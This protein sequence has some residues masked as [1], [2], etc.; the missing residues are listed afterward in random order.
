MQFSFLKKTLFLTFRQFC[1]NTILAQIDTICIF[2][3]PQN[4][5]KN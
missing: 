5:F 1:E 4:H 2:N 3:M